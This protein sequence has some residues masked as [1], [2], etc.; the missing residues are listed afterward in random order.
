[1]AV[2]LIL[3]AVQAVAGAGTRGRV[4]VTVDRPDPEGLP[5]GRDFTDPVRLRVTDD[6]PGIDPDMK[7]R[8][9]APFA[10]G[11]PGGTGLGLAIVQRAVEAHHG[12]VFVDS[13]PGSGTTFTIYLHTWRPSQ[14]IA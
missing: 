13:V 10:S 8:L 2:N 3:N 9:F 5:L 12:L 1:V 6:G 7:D 14:E 4:E 11:R